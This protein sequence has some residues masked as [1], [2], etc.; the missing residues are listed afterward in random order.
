MT[1]FSHKLGFSEVQSVIKIFFGFTKHI[2][3]E[4]IWLIFK[5]TCFITHP[6]INKYERFNICITR[7]YH[8]KYTWHPSYISPMLD[9]VST[10]T[11]GFN[12][13]GA[14]RGVA[15]LDNIID[16]SSKNVEKI[17]YTFLFKLQETESR[18]NSFVI[19]FIVVDPTTLL[20]KQQSFT[21]MPGSTGVGFHFQFIT[22]CHI[23]NLAFKGFTYSSQ[24]Y[25]IEF[26]LN[27]RNYDFLSLLLYG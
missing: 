10:S 5:Y 3:D 1:K 6:Y 19:G 15:V 26:F 27:F 24:G 16:T 20:P 22:K 8:C 12:D 14:V 23:P 7:L 11:I 25:N 2:P 18:V 21:K 9:I 13:T 4:L 17:G